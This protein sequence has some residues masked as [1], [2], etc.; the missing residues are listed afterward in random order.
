MLMRS[1]LAR[2]RRTRPGFIEPCQAIEGRKVPTGPQWIPRAKS[3]TAYASLVHKDRDR[4]RPDFSG[5]GAGAA[6]LPQPIS[7]ARLTVTSCPTDRCAH[8]CAVPARRVQGCRCASRTRT[9]TTCRLWS[10]NGR[11]WS[12]KLAAIT[13]AMASI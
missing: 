7:L 9:A 4:L 3:T 8:G 13:A 12:V 11:G 10:R 1:P 5:S 6:K 2:D